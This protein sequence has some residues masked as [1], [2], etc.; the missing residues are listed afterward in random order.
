MKK[1]C[2]VVESATQ[3]MEVYLHAET[4]SLH[5]FRWSKRKPWEGRYSAFSMAYPIVVA[6]SAG[7][8]NYLKVKGDGIFDQMHAAM[9][10]ET[11]KEELVKAFKPF[12]ETPDAMFAQLKRIVERAR[13]G[14]IRADESDEY[15]AE[16]V[17]VANPVEVARA[18]RRRPFAGGSP[19]D[20]FLGALLAGMPN[21]DLKTSRET[22]RGNPLQEAV[23]AATTRPEREEPDDDD[24]EDEDDWQS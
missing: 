9:S 3:R 5:F 14:R 8:G 18:T 24:E 7:V 11:A 23:H 21:A 6:L 10:I 2:F 4:D 20:S 19:F 15:C 16:S 13:P 1:L 22:S 12:C 17:E